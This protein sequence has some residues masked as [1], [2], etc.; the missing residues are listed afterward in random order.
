VDLRKNRKDWDKDSKFPIPGGGQASRGLFVCKVYA[1]TGGGGGVG[2]L[3]PQ[4]A[5]GEK[6]W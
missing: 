5:R 4:Q 2:R 6:L 1:T 3:R